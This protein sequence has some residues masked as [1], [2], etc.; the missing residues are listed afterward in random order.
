MANISIALFWYV[1]NLSGL[2]AFD[3]RKD[4]SLCNSIWDKTTVFHNFEFNSKTIHPIS[5]FLFDNDTY[6]ASPQNSVCVSQLEPFRNISY[7][8]KI[9]FSRCFHI[10]FRIIDNYLRGVS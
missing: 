5:I 6:M 4:C 10:F 1:I 3:F 9:L 7:L 2:R 8:Y